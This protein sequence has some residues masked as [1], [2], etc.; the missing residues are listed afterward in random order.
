MLKDEQTDDGCL[1]INTISLPVCFQIK[2]KTDELDSLK[3]A[4][5]HF[6]D[7]CLRR[8]GNL[9]FLIVQTLCFRENCS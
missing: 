9:K 1:S 5:C 3:L 6:I 2:L 4:I 8:L 7:K